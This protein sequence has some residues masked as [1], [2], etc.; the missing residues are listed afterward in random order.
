VRVLFL[1]VSLSACWSASPACPYDGG[2]NAS[3]CPSSY[4]AAQSICFKGSSTACTPGV[5]RPCVYRGDGDG[6]ENG[7]WLNAGFFCFELDAGVGEWR[8]AQ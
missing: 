6:M 2:P 1:A 3:T 7:C 5:D 8:C 4:G